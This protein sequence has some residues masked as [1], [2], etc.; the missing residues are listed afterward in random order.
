VFNKEDRLG[1]VITSETTTLVAETKDSTIMPSLGEFCLVQSKDEMII[2]ITSHQGYEPRDLRLPLALGLT[3]E[4][5]SEEQPQ[6]FNQIRNLW[7]I[8]I[9]GRLNRDDFSFIPFIPS[10][11][12]PIHSFVYP[13]D[14][15]NEKEL[16]KNSGFWLSLIEEVRKDES[17][18]HL[19]LAL[20]TRR[21]KLTND[22]TERW[23][24]LRTVGRMIAKGFIGQ[25]AR[26]NSLLRRMSLLDR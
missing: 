25:E 11:P 20:I 5:L 15:K 3:P 22:K 7:H 21:L 16:I 23:Q 24:L 18:D 2:G 17:F 10:S 26:M 1:E 19:F 12:A 14:D 13:I 4:E 9:L 6:I 8:L